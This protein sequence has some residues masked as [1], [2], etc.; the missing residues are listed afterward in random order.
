MQPELTDTSALVAQVRDELSPD[1]E[2]RAI[3]WK[4]A[5]LPQVYVDKI[6]FKQVWMNLLGNA[7]KYSRNQEHAEI[8]IGCKETETDYEFYVKDNGAGFDMKYADKLFGIFQRL[9]LKEE[10]EGTGIGLANAQ[11]IISRH[12]G[13]IWAHA[14]VGTGATFYFTLPKTIQANS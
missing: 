13:R 9:H 8:S 10:F 2:G 1:T 12:G 6:L 4:I 11:R 5:P 14:E 7:I 3:A